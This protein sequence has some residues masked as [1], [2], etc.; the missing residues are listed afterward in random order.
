M[1]ARL[2]VPA[3]D[4]PLDTLYTQWRGGGRTPTA[5]RMRWVRRSPMRGGYSTYA[6]TSGSGCRTGSQPTQRAG[7]SI[8]RGGFRWVLGVARGVGRRQR[9]LFRSASRYSRPS[10]PPI[11]ALA[12]PELLENMRVAPLSSIL[13]RP[14]GHRVPRVLCGV[15]PQQRSLQTLALLPTARLAAPVAAVFAG[16]LCPGARPSI[17]SD[18]C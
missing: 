1:R 9:P 5:R 14:R 10:Y 17:H 4:K 13:A 16:I 2:T 18:S 15:V 6:A 12:N 8:L 7:R 11:V 3:A